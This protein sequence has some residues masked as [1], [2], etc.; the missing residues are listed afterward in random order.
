[1]TESANSASICSTVGSADWKSLGKARVSSYWD[2]PIGLLRSRSAYSTMTRW[3]TW[4][5]MSPIDGWSASWRSRSS[6]TPQIEV[7]LAGILGLELAFL[8]VDDDEAAQPQMVEQQVDVEV[9]VADVEMDLPAD[10]GEP[11]PQF[12]QEAFQ[13]DGADLVSEFPL[14]ERLV[15][16]EE[17]EDVG[18]F[19]RLLD[20]VGLRRRQQPVESSSRPCPAGDGRRTRSCSSRTLRL[21]P[22]ASV[23]CMYQRRAGRSLTFSISTM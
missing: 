18:V 2:T 3:R 11:L 7:H 21:Q 6:T 10:E 12:E 9:V 1:M 14:V 8:Q 13:I 19:E 16:R 22:L 20:E 5:R 4:Q 15:E 17:V 23:C